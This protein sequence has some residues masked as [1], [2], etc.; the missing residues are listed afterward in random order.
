MLP[1]LSPLP[2]GWRLDSNSSIVLIRKGSFQP[3][4][5]RRFLRTSLCTGHRRK[6][7]PVRPDLIPPLVEQLASFKVQ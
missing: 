2:N 7:V 5:L 6:R 3:H 4:R 1:R